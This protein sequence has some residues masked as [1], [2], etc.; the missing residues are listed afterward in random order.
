MITVIWSDRDQ[1]MIVH[2]LITVVA[3]D[4][5]LTVVGVFADGKITVIGSDRDQTIIAH[6]RITIGACG[7]P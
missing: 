1:T 5:A 2:G 3:S 4:G 6:G 7:G